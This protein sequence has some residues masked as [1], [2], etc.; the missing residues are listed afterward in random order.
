MLK[1]YQAL[2]GQQHPAATIAQ[3]NSLANTGFTASTNPGLTNV[4][5]NAAAVAANQPNQ[6]GFNPQAST[7]ALNA[8]GFQ[9][10]PQGRAAAIAAGRGDLLGLPGNQVTPVVPPQAFAQSGLPEGRSVAFVS[11]TTVMPTSP[12]VV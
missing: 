3:N 1:Q 11:P 9:D 10:T 6:F 2:T 4:T 7:A 8:A 12:T 5:P